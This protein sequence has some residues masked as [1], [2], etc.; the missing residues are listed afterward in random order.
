MGVF[1]CYGHLENNANSGKFKVNQRSF[2]P[3]EIEATP[4]LVNRLADLGLPTGHALEHLGVSHMLFGDGLHVFVE[5][6]EDGELLVDGVQPSLEE[7]ELKFWVFISQI[8]PFLL[9]HL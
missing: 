9:A 4:H 8:F 6:V 2:E 3:N 1:D 5:F 7:A